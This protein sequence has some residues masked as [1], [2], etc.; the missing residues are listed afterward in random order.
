[1]LSWCLLVEIRQLD[2]K[3]VP[4]GSD[5]RAAVLRGALVELLQTHRIRKS[6]SSFSNSLSYSFM[7]IGVNEKIEKWCKTV[8]LCNR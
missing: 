7:L 2:L 4:L 6:E 3:V 5:P 1:M 8:G